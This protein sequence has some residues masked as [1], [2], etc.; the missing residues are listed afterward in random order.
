MQRRLSRP[1][2]ER[3]L[4]AHF[5]KI[6]LP[7]PRPR[8]SDAPVHTPLNLTAFLRLVVHLAQ[9]GYPAHW[10]AG[11]LTA[12]CNPDGDITTT[13][14]PPRK[15]VTD[16]ADV[17]AVLPPAKM[18]VA[19]WRAEFTT[20][21]TIWSRLLPFS[22][23]AS[24]KTLVAPTEIAEYTVTFPAFNDYQLRVLH[25]MLLFWDASQ[26]DVPPSMNRILRDDEKGDTSASARRIKRN[27]IHVF[28]AFQYVTDTRTASF[29]S[30]I[31]LIHAMKEGKWLV[32]IWRTD[33]WTR[34]TR[35]VDVQGGVLRRVCGANTGS[36]CSSRR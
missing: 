23:I 13:A 8:Y 2:L 15:M 26:G 29:W 36:A 18:M 16:Q 33:D 31:D 5:L 19:P 17:D 10:L 24:P 9:I 35:G 22:F 4:Y 12:L 3:W 34:V 21:L 28:Q 6:C 30:R 14:R 7:H 1:A 20:L 11:V 32:Y 27:A 25:F